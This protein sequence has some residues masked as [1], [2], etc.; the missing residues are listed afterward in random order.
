MNNIEYIFTEPLVSPRIAETIAREVGATI[1]I[2]NPI[3]GLTAHD[4]RAGKTYLSLMNE[5]LQNI[6]RALT[7]D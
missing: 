7:C 4:V 2:F 3:S 6:K 5:N 1:L